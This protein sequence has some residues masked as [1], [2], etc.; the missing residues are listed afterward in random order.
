MGNLGTPS[1]PLL[2]LLV[3]TVIVALLWMVALKP[4]AG[5][6]GPTGS[7]AGGGLGAYQSAIDRARAS[8]AAQNRA[9]AAGGA[10]PAGTAPAPRSKAAAPPTSAAAPSAR[11]A[12]RGRVRIRHA[13]IAASGHPS[14]GTSVSGVSGVTGVSGGPAQVSAALADERV[15]AILFYNPG[16]A[17]DRAERAEL[18]A[19][20][21]SR[22][23]LRLAVPIAD[24]AQYS[25]ITQQLPIGSSPT[26]VIV[27]PRHQA[28]LITGFAS[29]F[30]IAGRIAQALAVR[31]A[32]A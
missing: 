13:K 6:A 1:K 5:S 27:D 10:R 9:A 25:E 20:P 14:S 18:L 29:A 19:L 22:R 21:A 24:V 12:G 16:A 4:G 28:T 17:D 30:E 23:V 3:V 7:R 11:A 32:P 2:G 15:V 8:A 26:L 31:P